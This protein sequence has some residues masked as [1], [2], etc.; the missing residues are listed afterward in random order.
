MSTPLNVA[1][2]FLCKLTVPIEAYRDSLYSTV[3]IIQ[4]ILFTKV[5]NLIYVNFIDINKMIVYVSMH[6]SYKCNMLG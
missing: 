3:Y 6:S 1:F 4:C 5:I 2:C